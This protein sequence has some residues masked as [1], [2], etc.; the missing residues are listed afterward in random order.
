MDEIVQ[1]SKPLT[2]PPADRAPKPQRTATRAQLLRDVCMVL[3]CGIAVGFAV[4]QMRETRKTEAVLTD[5]KATVYERCL[6]RSIYDQAAH[7]STA[8]D[9]ALYRQLLDIADQAP[10][11]PDPRVRLL[12]V[13]QRAVIAKAQQRKE[14][15]AAAGVIGSCEQYKPR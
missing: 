15:A 14:A 6:Q 1:P 3:V 5:F 13:K 10:E 7:D 12:I 2:L 8:A 9:A 4:Y 11:N